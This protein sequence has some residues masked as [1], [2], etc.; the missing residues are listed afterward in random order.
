MVEEKR[1]RPARG[2]AACGDDGGAPG[3]L[4]AA[5]WADLDAER[6]TLS[7]RRSLGVV[8]RHGAGEEV[9]EGPT[10]T[11][12]ARV[13]DLDEQNVVALRS[14]RVA[15]AEI[16]LGLARQEALV[17]PMV[18]GSA[19]HP[20]RFTR[21]FGERLA[22]CRRELGDGAPPPIRL[23]DLRHTHA[24]LLLAAGTP[25][26]VV[27]ERLGHASPTITL[28]VYAHVMPGMGSEAA[29][30]LATLLYGGGALGV[31]DNVRR[32]ASPARRAVRRRGVVIRV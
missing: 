12:R 6:A 13:V 9:V 16:S 30:R 15:L 2:V 11:G 14:H 29:A 24:S 8:K 1:R 5:R 28:G 18:D 3:E 10:K 31:V 4:L 7:V 26:K 22:R 27:S 21:A 17:L 23:H 20:E 25:V 32:A 19:R